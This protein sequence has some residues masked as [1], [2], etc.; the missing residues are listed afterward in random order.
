MFYQPERGWFDPRKMRTRR[1]YHPNPTQN[2]RVSSKRPF[3]RSINE[4]RR[5]RV[6]S[7]K[8]QPYHYRPRPSKRYS[9]SRGRIR[10]RG[11]SIEFFFFR[12]ALIE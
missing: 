10:F 2:W 11:I 9:N 5:A 12:D 7:F 4:P 6:K 8:P 1:D 3:I